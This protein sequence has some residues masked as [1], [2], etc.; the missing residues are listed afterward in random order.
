MSGSKKAR[1]LCKSYWVER[2]MSVRGNWKWPS[3]GE[4][5]QPGE[6][7]IW[8]QRRVAIKGP[9]HGRQSVRRRK[10]E[11]ISWWDTTEGRPMRQ[12]WGALFWEQV[13]PGAQLFILPFATLHHISLVP[14]K[15]EA[16]SLEDPS[17]IDRVN[18]TCAYMRHMDSYKSTLN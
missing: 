3:P 12:E 10:C 4:G 2:D 17:L 18:S 9:G 16:K 5:P 13:I 14:C 1:K 15:S 6:L 7:M 8:C 11:G